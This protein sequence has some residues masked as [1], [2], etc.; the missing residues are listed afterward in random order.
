M[1]T[2]WRVV[3]CRGV[4]DWMIAMGGDG[5]RWVVIKFSGS[6]WKELYYLSITKN[7]APK[8]KVMPSSTRQPISSSS[9]VHLYH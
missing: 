5:R 2:W 6:K 8:M 4:L 9:P 1:G 3:V 7:A